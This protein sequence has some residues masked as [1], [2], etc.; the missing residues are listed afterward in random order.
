[1]L[2][3]QTKMYQNIMILKPQGKMFKPQTKMLKNIIIF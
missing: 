1:M 2:K 3:L